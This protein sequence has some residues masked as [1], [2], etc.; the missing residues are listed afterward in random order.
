MANEKVVDSYYQW[1]SNDFSSRRWIGYKRTILNCYYDWNLSWPML[2]QF[3]LF[4]DHIEIQSGWFGRNYQDLFFLQLKASDGLARICLKLSKENL[5]LE[6]LKITMSSVQ[7][8][9]VLVD[10]SV[11][12][13][14]DLFLYNFMN[15]E[16]SYDIPNWKCFKAKKN[17]IKFHCEVCS[18]F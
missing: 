11:N 3:K 6:K 14:N 4:S 10:S 7:D 8:Q 5:T 13:S 1:G 16:I 2:N 18:S 9:R 15:N 17:D 12:M